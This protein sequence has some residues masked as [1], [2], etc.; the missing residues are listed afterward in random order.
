M[1]R[2]E[3]AI[4][5]IPDNVRSVDCFGRLP[6]MY[7]HTPYELRSPFPYPLEEQLTTRTIPFLE[8]WYANNAFKPDAIIWFRDAFCIELNH[9]QI[10]FLNENY[11][12]INDD[13]QGITVYTRLSP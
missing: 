11:Q 1:A 12:K 5:S 6:G 8:Q 9:I 7:L 3:A 13:S 2:M 4:Q 10:E